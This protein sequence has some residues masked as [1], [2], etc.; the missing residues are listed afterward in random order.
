MSMITTAATRM[1]VLEMR[2]VSEVT[3]TLGLVLRTNQVPMLAQASK[4][5]QSRR[6]TQKKALPRKAWP[7]AASCARGGPKR[8]RPCLPP[9]RPGAPRVQ[10]RW[11]CWGPAPPASG[12]GGGTVAAGRP[13]P[14]ASSTELQA[15]TTSSASCSAAGPRAARLRPVGPRAVPP[16]PMME[17]AS[18]AATRTWPGRSSVTLPV[19]TGAVAAA[20]RTKLQIHQ[21]RQRQRKMRAAAGSERSQPGRTR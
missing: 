15:R 18:A 20:V 11:R 8:W 21:W 7:K 1:A 16:V 17:R 19:T 5:R 10:L 3:L 12:Q 14:P 13:L 4:I 2:R 9:P 6:D